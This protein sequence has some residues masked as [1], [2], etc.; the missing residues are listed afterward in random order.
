MWHMGQL[1]ELLSLGA[2]CS[3]CGDQVHIQEDFSRRAGWCSVM[4]LK[5]VNK[6]CCNNCDPPSVTTSP[7]LPK[8]DDKEGLPGPT[9]ATINRQLVLGMRDIGKG[10]AGALRLAAHLGLPP[11]VSEWRWAEQTEKLRDIAS[12]TL[13]TKFEEAVVKL[14]RVL[15]EKGKMHGCD[16]DTSVEKLKE[17]MTDIEVSVDGSWGTTGLSSQTGVVS[18]IAIE[19]VEVI[20]QH[21]MHSN[22]KK[23]AKWEGTSKDDPK[24]L[25]F[26]VKH[27]E[28]CLLNHTGSSQSMEAEGAEILWGRSIRK[29][30][31]RYTTFV[32]DGDSKSY[33]RVSESRP[34]G[35][36]EIRKREC[37]GE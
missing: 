2:R 27:F 7:F 34:Y 24:Y 17:T 4:L 21:I 15:A 10:R 37:I 11:P 36:V 12:E 13:E 1:Q 20:D 28:H 31:L 29:H 18:I 9:S 32:G 25:E 26:I 35:D 3:E 5:C 23:C 6:D 16:K 30:N 19:T 8:T 33:K 14:K 22:C